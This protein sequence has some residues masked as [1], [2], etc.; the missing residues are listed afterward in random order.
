MIYEKLNYIVAVAEEQNITR[1]AKRLFIS[2]PTL[3]QHLN[4]LEEELGAKLF[5]RSKNPVTLTAIGKT[6]LE[7]MKK[8]ADLEAQLYNNI[9]I[10][11]APSQ[12]LVV[13]I[14]NVRGSYWIPPI[15]SYFCAKY[16]DIDIQI[17]QCTEERMVKVLCD[18]EMDLAI[19]TMPPAPDHLKTVYLG[20]ENMVFTAHKKFGL[21]PPGQREQYGLDRP[22]IIEP[23]RLDRMPFIV[24]QIGNG[25]YSNYDSVIRQKNIH[26]SRTISSNNLSTGFRLAQRGLGVQL[27]YQQFIPLICA[28]GDQDT[29]DYFA[30]E[31]MPIGRRCV[32]AYHRDTVKRTLVTDFI[33]ILQTHVLPTYWPWM[34]RTDPVK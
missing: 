18:R 27:T 11:A 19:G 17:I 12:T 9:R 2:Q 3:T 34:Y 14:S 16:P 30:F 7:E 28:N 10:A 32:A 1:A 23:Q 5:D 24:P 33:Q 6:Y 29:M 13:G 4:R 26:P 21:V 20:E 15:L 8:I 22:Y 25:I 31:Q